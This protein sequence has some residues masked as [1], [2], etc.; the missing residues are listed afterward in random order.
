MERWSKYV[1]EEVVKENGKKGKRRKRLKGFTAETPPP[2]G[3]K[4][5]MVKRQKLNPL[6]DPNKAYVSRKERPEWN[7]VGLL[8]R[9]RIRVGQTVLATPR[10]HRL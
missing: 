6:W 2:K 3:A 1:T 8:G 9:V 4:I 7:I 5:K 10:I